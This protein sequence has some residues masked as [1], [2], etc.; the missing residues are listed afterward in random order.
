MRRVVWFVLGSI[1]VARDAATSERSERVA[2]QGANGREPGIPARSERANEMA[3]K[4][5]RQSS[6]SRS[7]R[8]RPP[9]R[10]R[11]APR[12]VRTASIMDFVQA[13]QRGDRDPARHGDPGGDHDLRG[14]F[15]HLHPEDPPDAAAAASG[16]RHREGLADAAA[17]QAGRSPRPTSKR[18]PRSRCPTSTPTTSTA[19]RSRSA[20]PPARWASRSADDASATS[21]VAPNAA[22]SG[23]PRPAGSPR[24]SHTMS[25]KK[26]STR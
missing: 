7:R 14:S 13:V 10:R 19:P 9:R 8:A 17:G 6:R 20:A 26:Y 11:S 23:R 22:R 18:S 16:G 4:K 1:R 3:K 12:S 25:G 2:R 24:G 21:P 15:L 5:L